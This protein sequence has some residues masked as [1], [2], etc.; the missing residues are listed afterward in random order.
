MILKKDDYKFDIDI[1][2][3]E[4]YYK[5]QSLCDCPSCRNFYAQISSCFPKLKK[6][7]EEFGV[8][9]SKPDEIGYTESIEEN[10][11][12][13]TFVAYTVNG[14]ITEFSGYEIDIYDSQFLSVVVDCKYIPNEQ[15]TDDYFILNVYNIELPW[16]LNEPFPTTKRNCFINKTSCIFKKNGDTT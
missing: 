8:D 6:F 10:M 14:K 2:K 4:E 9:V 16:V 11:I 13:Y 15:K 5:E 3:T 7:L 12:D 1:N